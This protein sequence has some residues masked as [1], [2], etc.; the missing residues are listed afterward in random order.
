MTIPY[1]GYAISVASENP[2]QA[3]VDRLRTEVGFLQLRLKANGPCNCA[4][5]SCPE[6]CTCQ[7]ADCPVCGPNMEKTGE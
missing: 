5:D 7:Y 1:R 4:L 3:E 6:C 2:L